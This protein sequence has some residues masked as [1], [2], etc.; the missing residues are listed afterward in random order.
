M[1]SPRPCF[2]GLLFWRHLEGQRPGRWITRGL[3]VRVAQRS[4]TRRTDTGSGAG[5]ATNNRRCTCSVC[6]R[7]W[8]P[9]PGAAQKG[10][11]RLRL[12]PWAFTLPSCS[13]LSV[14]RRCSR[15]PPSYRSAAP[16]P[17]SGRL[18]LL[19]PRPPG[20]D[21]RAP[22]ANPKTVDARHSSPFRDPRALLLRPFPRCP[23]ARDPPQAL[24]SETS[25][26]PLSLARGGER[27]GVKRER[28]LHTPSLSAE[29]LA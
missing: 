2:S 29:G 6:V 20:L 3:G 23:G 8:L 9:S 15:R 5:R 21:P 22:S 25:E 27:P 17:V 4:W 10:P 28:S 13:P 18:F 16:A 7:C 26:P 1:L 11:L 14:R 12:R 19:G 24:P